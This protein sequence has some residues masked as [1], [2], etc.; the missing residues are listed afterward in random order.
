MHTTVSPSGTVVFTSAKSTQCLFA[1]RSWAADGALGSELQLSDVPRNGSFSGAD[2]VT[3]DKCPLPQM[4][5]DACRFTET[6]VD[7]CRGMKSSAT[8]A[9]Q[10]QLSHV[11]EIES[12]HRHHRQRTTFFRTPRDAAAESKRFT[13]ACWIMPRRDGIVAFRRH[14]C[15]GAPLLVRLEGSAI[16][17][18]YLLPVTATGEL[19]PGLSHPRWCIGEEEMPLAAAADIH[20]AQNGTPLGPEDYQQPTPAALLNEVDNPLVQSSAAT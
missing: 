18:G 6:S 16:S 19:N 9:Q 2:R 10:D 14:H 7:S 12:R 15:Q 11:A 3:K 1:Y 20:S 17:K 5:L 4:M 8:A 13:S